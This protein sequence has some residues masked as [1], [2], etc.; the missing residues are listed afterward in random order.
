MLVDGVRQNVSLAKAYSFKITASGNF[1][2]DQAGTPARGLD[3]ETTSPRTNKKYS[4]V[5]SIT[6][7]IQER[8]GVAALTRQAFDGADLSQVATSLLISASKNPED[9][10]ALMDLSVIEQLK[11]NL[12]G[13]LDYQATALE[14]S[15]MFQIPP[16]GKADLTLLVLAAPIHMGGNTPVE[17]LLHGSSVRIITCYVTPHT[18]LPDPLPE[19]DL[20][21]VAA[22]GDSGDTLQFLQKIDRQISGF[23]CPIINYPQ[24]IENLERDRLG[25]L[26]ADVPGLLTTITTRATRSELLSIAAGGKIKTTD[27]KIEGFPQVIRPVGSHAGQFLSR[28]SNSEALEAYLKDCTKSEFFCTPYIDYRSDDG[29]FRKYRIVFVDGEPFPCHMAIA[30][31]WAVWYMNAEMSGNP[32]KRKEEERFM[33]CFDEGFGARHR[34]CLTEITK[35]IDLEYFG[36]DCA[37]DQNGNLIVFEADNALIVHDMDCEILYPYKKPQMQKI[38]DAFE[39]SLFS[40]SFAGVKGN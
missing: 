35:R 28:I 16:A 8:L 1:F 11:G 5:P 34:E 31:Q 38:F 32:T 37:E 30:D 7:P 18:E 9:A 27:P 10:A 36:I 15:Q 33:T 26:L 13:G 24:R 6:Q 22:P 40:R 3:M 14:K 4:R 21:F 29:Q 17:F 12:H 23:D 25:H 2:A 39:A 20:V 19:H